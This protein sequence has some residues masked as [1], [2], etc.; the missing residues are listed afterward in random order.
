MHHVLVGTIIR[1]A[2]GSRISNPSIFL[3]K[4]TF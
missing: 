3:A 1:L 2:L 4:D